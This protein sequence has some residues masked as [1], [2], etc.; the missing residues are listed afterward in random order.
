MAKIYKLDIK[1]FRGIKDFS[2]TF[3]DLNLICFVGRGDSGK[4]TIL[5]AIYYVLNPNWN[6]VFYDTDFYNSN[7]DNPIEIEATLIDLPTELLKED[8]YGLHIRG[9]DKINNEIRDDLKDD[10]EKALT[11]KLEVKKDLE[12]K[13]YIINSRQEN[14]ILISAYDRKKLNTFMISDYLDI[15]FSWRNGSPLYSLLKNQDF[16]VSVDTILSNINRGVKKEIDNYPFEQFKNIINNITKEAEYL[17][18]TINDISTSIDFKDIS[19]NEGK[20]S[21]HQDKIPLRLKG[22]GTKR[23]L[24]IAIQMELVKCGGIILIDEIEQGLEPDRIKNLIRSL[25]KNTKGQ[26]FIATHSQGVIEELEVK[27]IFLINKNGEDQTKCKNIDENF[28]NL[29]RACPEAIYAKKVIVCEGKTEIGICRAL[30]NYNRNNGNSNF[31][32]LDIVYTDGRGDNFPDRACKLKKLGLDVCVI[33]D[34]DKD[35]EISPTKDEMSKQGIQ[36]FDWD[37]KNSIEQQVFN[38]LPCSGIRELWEYIKSENNLSEE[39]LKNTIQKE[40]SKDL[41]DNWKKDDSIKKREAC[42]IIAN[43]DKWF[44]RIDHGEFLGNIIFKYFNEIKDKKLGKQL[45]LLLNWTKHE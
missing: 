1:N 43:Q 40:L 26:I 32:A 38:D 2:C 8:K 44:K 37:D 21:L 25:Y 5:N 39:S 29:T 30:D 14:P 42:G 11:I 13:W 31:S 16:D 19:I 7:T 36:I 10:Y 33:C 45:E 35:N 9:I 6:L 23:L 24:S 15:H 27:N 20:L 17:G 12:P 41:N 28:Q 34:S 22:K 3:N 18:I 4:T